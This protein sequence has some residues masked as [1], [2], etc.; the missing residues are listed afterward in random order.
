MKLITLITI[1]IFSLSENNKIIGLWQSLDTEK[2]KYL[3]FKTGGNLFEIDK[4]ETNIKP[5]NMDDK[6]INIRQGN[7]SFSE[8]PYYFSG[9]TL[10]IQ[11]IDK[12]KIVKEKYIKRAISL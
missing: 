5:Y 9:D 3:D 8:L 1:F 4:D 10:I 12:G 7:G 2:T 6:S 11:K